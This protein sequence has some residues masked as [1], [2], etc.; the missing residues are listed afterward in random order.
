MEQRRQLQQQ[1]PAEAVDGTAVS[2]PYAA[3]ARSSTALDDTPRPVDLRLQ[4][5]A[6]KLAFIVSKR[7]Q[8]LAQAGFT[9]RR[10]ERSTGA[11]TNTIQDYLDRTW[12]ARHVSCQGFNPL[13]G[14]TSN[15]DCAPAIGYGREGRDGLQ[16]SA[17]RAQCSASYG[18]PTGGGGG[19][20]GGSDGGAAGSGGV[21]GG[22]ARALD[23]VEYSG[24]FEEWPDMMFVFCE[25]LGWVFLHQATEAAVEVV[26]ALFR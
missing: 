23:F 5:Q 24:R 2:S 14:S 7:R 6:S 15:V 10:E 8:V 22:G 1:P 9:L 26:Q 18:G 3:S 16:I 11:S 19:D 4:L 17:L 21:G 20:G 13:L 25:E 12:A